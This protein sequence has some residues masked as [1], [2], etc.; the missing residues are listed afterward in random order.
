MTTFCIVGVGCARGDR[1]SGGVAVQYDVSSFRDNRRYL[2]ISEKSSVRTFK[3]DSTPRQEGLDRPKL[4]GSPSRSRAK[5]E[6]SEGQ[7]NHQQDLTVVKFI[8]QASANA[9][10]S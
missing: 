7:L 6:N 8:L 1:G 9:Y 5:I 10:N 3:L 4:Q 2:P